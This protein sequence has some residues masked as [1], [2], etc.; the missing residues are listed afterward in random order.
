MP[1]CDLLDIRCIFVNELVGSAFLSIILASILFFVF[2]SKIK[3]GFRTSIVVGIPILLIFGLTLTGFS[4]L[5]AFIT[6]LLGFMLA[7]VF[8]KLIGNR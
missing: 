1:G 8:Q 4:T 2:S 7:A 6:V 3:V 5:Y